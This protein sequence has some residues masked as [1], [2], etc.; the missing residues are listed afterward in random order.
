M[1][2]KRNYGVWFVAVLAGIILSFSV[3]I[4]DTH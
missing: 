1:K 3:T 4:Q 2:N